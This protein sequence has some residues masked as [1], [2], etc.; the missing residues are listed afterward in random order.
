MNDL[1]ALHEKDVADRDVLTSEL[2]AKIDELTQFQANIDEEKSRIA[3]EIEQKYLDKLSEM[4]VLLKAKEEEHKRNVVVDDELESEKRRV[5]SL[6]DECEVLKCRLAEQ[7]E[8]STEAVDEQNRKTEYAMKENAHLSSSLDMVKKKVTELEVEVCSLSD[9]IKNLQSN[10]SSKD[11]ELVE[12]NLKLEESVNTNKNSQEYCS[13]LENRLSTC[14][15]ELSQ[16]VADREQLQSRFEDLKNKSVVEAEEAA[17]QLAATAQK[18][19]ELSSQISEQGTNAKASTCLN[20]EALQ[21]SVETCTEKLVAAEGTV[22]KYKQMVKA[23]MKEINTLSESI[24]K[25]E[26]NIRSLEEVNSV[27]EQQIRELTASLSDVERDVTTHEQIRANEHVE[28]KE[29]LSQYQSDLTS[30]RAIVSEREQELI[31]WKDKCTS[32]ETCNATLI[33]QVAEKDK[34]IHQNN[35]EAL[36]VVKDGT[37]ESDR[38]VQ[39][40]LERHSESSAQY[41]LTISELKEEIDG[42]KKQVQNLKNAMAVVNENFTTK[43]EKERADTLAEQQVLNAKIKRLKALLAKSG[44]S[45]K[46]KDAEIAQLRKRESES[47][48]EQWSA[49]R[50]LMRVED[51]KNSSGLPRFSAGDEQACDVWCLL[52]REV[53]NPVDIET[54]VVRKRCSSKWVLESQMST[55]MQDNKQNLVGEIPAQTIQQEHVEIIRKIEEG[56]LENINDLKA[57]ISTVTQNFQAYK[58]KA[59]TALKRLGKDEHDERLKQ[60]QAEDAEISQLRDE[61][62]SLQNEYEVLSLTAKESSERNSILQASVDELTKALSEAED[63]VEVSVRKTEDVEN[64]LSRA[65]ESRTALENVVSGL[66]VEVEDL[67]EQVEAL[68]NQLEAEKLETFNNISQ[69]VNLASLPGGSGTSAILARTRTL[70]NQSSFSSDHQRNNSAIRTKSEADGGII[71]SVDSMSSKDIDDDGGHSSIGPNGNSTLDGLRDNVSMKTTSN[72][73]AVNEVS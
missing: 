34:L 51:C 56:H 60:R 35:E 8:V 69:D 3:T 22:S 67:Q 25:A 21:L 53:E 9:T 14:L 41:E 73:M 7:S 48:E 6:H 10:I 40:L 11:D 64:N 39:E 68:T 30:S 55:Y 12:I 31:E 4:E 18:V 38:K 54:S 5:E 71:R 49:F 42:E 45:G 70:N 32:L 52:V 44:A 29:T 15:E 46:E 72:L 65:H 59:H 57:E 17:A 33:A 43:F 27:L 13:S 62:T 23:K 63:R 58:A 36:R 28:L 2:Q 37:S 24:K 1:S 16:V 19:E 20:C 26:S 50:V 66:K 61:I 47:I